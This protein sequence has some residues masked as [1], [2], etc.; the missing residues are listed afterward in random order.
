VSNLY[1]L[2]SRDRIYP[3]NALYF[4]LNCKT[5]PTKLVSWSKKACFHVA[6]VQILCKEARIHPFHDY[7]KCGM[8]T[9][10]IKKISQENDFIQF[11]QLVMFVSV[12]VS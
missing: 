7:P 1:V 2:Q 3:K 12:S 9:G 11:I 4:G 8:Q 5:V 10:N 6:H